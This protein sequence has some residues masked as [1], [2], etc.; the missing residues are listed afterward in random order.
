[1]KAKT[2]FFFTNKIIYIYGS[3]NINED[4]NVLK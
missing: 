4:L 2:H 3:E 1:M